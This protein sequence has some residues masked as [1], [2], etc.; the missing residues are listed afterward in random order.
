MLKKQMALSLTVLIAAAVLFIVVTFAWLTVSEIVDIDDTF[1]TLEDVDATVELQVSTDAE[2]AVYT[3]VTGGISLENA[4]PG[5]VF[6]YRIWIQNTGLKAIISRVVFYGFTDGPSDD[7]VAYDAE[8]SLINCLLL[9]SY[10]TANSLTIVD[11]LISTRIG[12]LSG[13]LTY[14]NASFILVNNVDIAVADDEY[15]YFTFTVA[16]NAGNEYQNLKL[17]IATIQIQSAAD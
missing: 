1:I 14:A 4:V 8:Q 15:V 16:T 9:N 6:Y 5:D 11:E 13:G 3:K 17:T 12:E 7:L 10:N 2:H